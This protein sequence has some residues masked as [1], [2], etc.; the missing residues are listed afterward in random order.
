[1]LQQA[2]LALG[3]QK[4]PWQARRTFAR[5]LG[6]LLDR[7]HRAR[8]SLAELGVRIEF[9]ADPGPHEILD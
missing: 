4:D 7:P 5:L 3:S 8:E 9:G 1:V 2:L 6:G